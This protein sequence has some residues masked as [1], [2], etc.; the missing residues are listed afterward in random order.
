MTYVLV[1][2][3]RARDGEADKIAELL[4]ELVQACKREPG[5]ITFI[6]HRSRTDPDEFLLYEQY[7][8]EAAY[9]EHQ[10]TAHFKT[11]VLER[12]VPLLAQRQRLPFNIVA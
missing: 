10:T 12:A 2:H 4:P 8:D 3:W 11:L 5:V 7:R 1:A 9:L 6:A